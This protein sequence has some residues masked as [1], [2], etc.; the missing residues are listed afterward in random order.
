MIVLKVIEVRSTQKKRKEYF[1]DQLLDQS[2]FTS[3]CNFWILSRDFKFILRQ[4]ST[5]IHIY[6]VFISRSDPIVIL[7]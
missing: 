6:K 7:K 3:K 1:W 4:N 2:S 5:Y